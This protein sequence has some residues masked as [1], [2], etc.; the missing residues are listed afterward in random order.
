MSCWRA[1][2]AEM[3]LQASRQQPP[4]GRPAG[5]LA[6]LRGLRRLPRPQLQQHDR[7]T[8]QRDLPQDLKDLGVQVSCALRIWVLD[9]LPRAHSLMVTKPP[10]LR[11]ST[12]RY[13]RPVSEVPRVPSA[14][15]WLPPGRKSSRDWGV[16]PVGLSGTGASTS[17]HRG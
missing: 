2:A 11:V 14:P 12:P 6:S 15:P 5:E 16:R 1:A 17:I 3:R 10:D 4:M 13:R 8:V 9:A 7:L